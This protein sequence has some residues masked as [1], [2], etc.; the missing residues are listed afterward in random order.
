MVTCCR[1]Y[2]A[3]DGI[4]LKVVQNKAEAYPVTCPNGTG[5][6]GRKLATHINLAF[7]LKMN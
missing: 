3:V 2:H 6:G 7:R 4:M 1:W 5:I